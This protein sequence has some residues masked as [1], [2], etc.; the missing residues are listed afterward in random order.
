[1]S[2]PAPADRGALLASPELRSALSRF[3]RGRVPEADVEDVVQATLTDALAAHKA[4]SEAEEVR[5]WVFGIAKN[6]IVDVHRKAKREVGSDEAPGDEAVAESAPLS[7]RDLLRWAE[8]ELPEGEG[9]DSTLEWMLREGAGEKLEHIA[10]D[11]QLPPARVRQRVSRMRRHFR[12]R[13]AAQLAAAAVLVVLAVWAIWRG[14]ATPGP[15]LIAPRPEAP[16]PEDQARELRRV[17]LERCDAKDWKLC[18]EGLD[19]A[20]A[21]DPIGDTAERIQNAREA[22]VRALAPEPAPVPQQI[23]TAAPNELERKAAPVRSSDGSLPKRP[24][25]PSTKKLEGKKR[26]DLP[27]QGSEPMQ[28]APAKVEAQAPPKGD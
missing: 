4:P 10:A 9:A 12:A 27:E 17:A 14:R 8:K 2:E 26:F 25:A 22:A 18:L 24:P 6:K 23:P 16:T 11:A 28:R 3:V 19:R 21:L 15:E 20:K 7:A 13:W 5:R 1:M